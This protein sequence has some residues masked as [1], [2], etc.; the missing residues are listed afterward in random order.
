MYIIILLLLLLCIIYLL[1]EVPRNELFSNR[2]IMLDESS[3]NQYLNNIDREKS[4]QIMDKL[5][6]PLF[7]S[8]KP[9]QYIDEH[10]LEPTFTT[11]QKIL[12]DEQDIV[13]GIN[14]MSRHK[15]YIITKN[16]GVRRKQSIKSKNNIKKNISSNKLSIN[17]DH[18]IL[19]DFLE[20]QII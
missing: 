18:G 14:N 4:N 12:D 7:V 16:K 3:K 19:S 5:Y 10:I 13:I 17:K 15:Y 6:Q 11:Y 1:L 2:S 20:Y 9:K 8:S